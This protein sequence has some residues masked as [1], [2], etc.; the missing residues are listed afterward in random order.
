LLAVAPDLDLVLT[1]ESRL[2]HLAADRGRGLL[3]P[4][5]PGDVGPVDVVVPGDTGGEAEVLAEV[6]A[7]ALGEELL[8]SV[9]VLGL[10]RVGIGLDQRASVRTEL[11]FGRVDTGRGG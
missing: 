1:G 10:G 9:A 6:A 11:P 7:H 3:P 5:G 8:P 4:A 2:G